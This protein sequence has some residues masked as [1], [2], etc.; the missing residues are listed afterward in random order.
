LQYELTYAR[1]K[2]LSIRIDE[3]GTIHVRAPYGLPRRI[4]DELVQGKSAWILEKQALVQ[5]RRQES[6]ILLEGGRKTLPYLGQDYPVEWVDGTPPFFD[7]TCFHMPT[8]SNPEEE[9]KMI[10]ALYQSLLLNK[11]RPIVQ[12]YSSL[13]GVFPQNLRITRARTRWGSCSGANNLNFSWRL[14]AAEESVIRYVVIHE[15]A[16][17]R[18]HNHSPRFWR[19]VGEWCPDYLI[20]R[21]KLKN[22]AEKLNRERL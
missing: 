21:Q 16:H 2:T 7:M 20:L 11:I 18:E 15:L 8:P 4:C 13:L 6:D 3:A 17:I 22:L 1:Q 12:N 9:L 19:I 10:T 14:L 5:K